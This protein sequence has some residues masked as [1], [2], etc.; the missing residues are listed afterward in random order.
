MSAPD[1]TVLKFG[2]SVLRSEDDLRPV[3][4]EIGRHVAAGSL[5]VAVVSAIG[6]ST[7]ALLRQA[8]R[9]G[10]L[11]GG[12]TGDGAVAALLATGETTSAALLGLALDCIGV[13]FTVLDAGRVGP[14]THGPQLDA[15]P[16]WFDCRAVNRALDVRPVAVLPGFVG[17]DDEGSFSLLGRGGSDLSAI[18]MAEWI[19]P[20]STASSSWPVTS[21]A[22][23]SSRPS[24]IDTRDTIIES[25]RV[26]CKRIW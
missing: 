19:T 24:R 25:A 2:S 18:A 3:A 1:L 22:S 9:L 20:E 23:S 4:D 12:G 13:P 6:D 21:R 11:S 14:F 16:Y 17:R 15:E 8:R 10:G 7:E 26:E 5:V